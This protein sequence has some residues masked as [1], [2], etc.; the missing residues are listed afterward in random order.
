MRTQ[1]QL[2][3]IYRN[4]HRRGMIKSEVVPD[5]LFNADAQ[6]NQFFRAGREL[7]TIERLLQLQSDE[8]TSRL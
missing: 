8:N 1:K 2:C 6:H 4:T 7:Y 3:A 5:N